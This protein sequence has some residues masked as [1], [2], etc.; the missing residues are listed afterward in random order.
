[1]P[2]L[3]RFVVLKYPVYAVVLMKMASAG[4]VTM[5][6]SA[7]ILQ[8]NVNLLHTAIPTTKLVVPVLESLVACGA[9]TLE[10]ASPMERKI[11][12]IL[13]KIPITALLH[14]WIL[15]VNSPLAPLVPRL[16]VIGV[17]TQANAPQVQSLVAKRLLKTQV[18]VITKHSCL[19]LQ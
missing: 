2:L 11:V 10:H 18:T 12:T 1:M 14:L 9:W 7:Q 17:L 15:A 6:L 13:P 8:E 3:P 5:N 16:D 19:L 4:F